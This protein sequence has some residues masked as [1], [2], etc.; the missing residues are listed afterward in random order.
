ML[1]E[2]SGTAGA[3]LHVGPKVLDTY[4]P[5]ICMQYKFNLLSVKHT[6]VLSNGAKIYQTTLFL[7][8]LTTY[9]SNIGTIHLGPVQLFWFKYEVILIISRWHPFN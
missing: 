6:Q 8:L 2:K 3:V 9:I 5:Y 7:T 4:Q 1:Q